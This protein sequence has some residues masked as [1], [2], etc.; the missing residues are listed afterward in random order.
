MAW[1]GA[2]TGENRSLVSLCLT[3]T[4]NKCLDRVYCGQYTHELIPALTTASYGRG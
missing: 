3:I 1:I 4:K 2:V